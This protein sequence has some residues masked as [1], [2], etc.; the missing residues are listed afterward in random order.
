MN[1]VTLHAL[2]D[3]TRHS[4]E[5]PPDE[6]AS[7]VC[8]LMCDACEKPANAYCVECS[9]GMCIEHVMVGL[10]GHNLYTIF[11]HVIGQSTCSFRVVL[12]QILLYCYQ[13]ESVR[14]HLMLFVSKPKPQSCFLHKVMLERLVCLGLVLYESHVAIK[15]ADCAQDSLSIILSQESYI[16]RTT[17]CT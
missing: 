1:D 12:A 7:T 3:F 10:A 4:K 2:P 16:L 5:E 15:T 11:Y 6:A 14:F 8:S 9:K 17:T 13:P